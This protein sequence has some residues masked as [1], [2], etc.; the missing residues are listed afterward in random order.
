MDITTHSLVGQAR[1]SLSL[2]LSLS[3]SH[4]RTHTHTHTQTHARTHT[5]THTQW[6]DYCLPPTLSHIYWIHINEALLL[7][8]WV[9]IITSDFLEAAEQWRWGG[10]LMWEEDSWDPTDVLSWKWMQWLTGWP[11]ACRRS[12]T[13]C[14]SLWWCSYR[15]LFFFLSLSLSLSSILSLSCSH[16]QISIPACW[17]QSHRAWLVP[18]CSPAYW[19]AWH[20]RRQTAW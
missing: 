5:H 10:E 9:I 11:Y 14:T 1:I 13:D 8:V 18:G 16:K 12:H 20:L 19:K 15:Q 3:P 2:S 17:H 6:R 4:T 7:C